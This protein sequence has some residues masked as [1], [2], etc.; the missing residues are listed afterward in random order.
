MST[1][2]L[3]GYI[4]EGDYTAEYKSHDSYPGGLGEDFLKDCLNGTIHVIEHESISFIKDSLFCEWAYFYN[5]DNKEFEIY[6]GVQKK[7]QNGNP[8]GQN[9]EDGYYPCKLIFRGTLENTKKLFNDEWF[10]LPDSDDSSIDEST[11]NI[12]EK[13]CQIYMRDNKLE[14]IINDTKS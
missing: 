9:G 14:A 2:G 3:F 5:L 10:N 7:P 13:K 8:F 6:K 11:D 1:R 12:F 4:I